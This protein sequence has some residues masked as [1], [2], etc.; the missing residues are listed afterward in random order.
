MKENEEAKSLIL[1]GYSHPNFG[2]S[3]FDPFISSKRIKKE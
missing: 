3:L 2:G 1:E